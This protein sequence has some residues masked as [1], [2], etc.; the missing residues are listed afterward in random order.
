MTKPI[1]TP[2]EWRRR[3]DLAAGWVAQNFDSLAVAAAIGLDELDAGLDANEA[4]MFCR[5]IVWGQPDDF[6]GIVLVLP[7]SPVVGADAVAAAHTPDQPFDA[8]GIGVFFLARRFAERGDEEDLAAAVELHDL[9]V[10]LGDHLWDGAGCA[11]LG[12]AAAELFAL[13]GDEAFLATTERAADTL[14][15]MQDPRGAVGTTADTARIA[16]FLRDMADA[17]EARRAAD[18]DPPL[19][20]ETPID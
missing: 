10:A 17:V 13:T 16:H 20:A 2:P 7:G 1:T 8:L 15:E 12:R 5:R 14:C 6:P 19:E 3:A 18:L 4:A 11:A 9:A